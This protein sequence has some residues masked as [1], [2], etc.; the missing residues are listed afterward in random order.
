MREDNGNKTLMVVIIALLSVFLLVIIGIVSYFLISGGA[1]GQTR[2]ASNPPIIH[3][4]SCLDQV[5]SDNPDVTIEGVLISD[6]ESCSLSIN[7][8]VVATTTSQE[9]QR[10]WSKTY[11]LNPGE[12]REFKIEAKDSENVVTTEKKTVFCQNLKEKKPTPSITAGC[13][14]VKK[15]SGGLNIRSY[16]GTEY[17]VV[18]FINAND[19]TSRMTFV[20][21]Y[22]VD[23]LGYTWYE[24]VSPRGLHGYVRSDLVRAV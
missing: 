20:G 4:V 15:K 9:V 24:V 11:T 1:G 8:E 16:A 3:I 18:D 21:R 23:Y 2:Q 5:D 7:G 12:T 13:S 19:Y 10:K 14:F 6:A 17:P 22:K